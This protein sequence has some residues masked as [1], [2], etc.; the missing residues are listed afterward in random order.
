LVT[1][2]LT[3]IA[4]VV[5]AYIFTSM[6]ARKKRSG[7]KKAFD[8][9]VLLDYITPDAPRSGVLAGKRLVFSSL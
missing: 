4:A 8:Y 2:G 5:A 7:Q 3:G 6:R 9:S 1:A